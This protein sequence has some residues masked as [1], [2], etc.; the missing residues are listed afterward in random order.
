MQKEFLIPEEDLREIACG[1]GYCIAPDTI[2]VQGKRVRRM[3][4]VMP[5]R[6]QDSGW[7]FFAGNETPEY[8]SRPGFTGIYDVNIVANYCPEIV[9]FLDSP[10]YSAYELDEDG[11]WIDTSSVEAWGELE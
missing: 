1:Y 5:Q 3:Y 11:R 10:P 4:R 8:L 9:P 2:M 6:Y 7:R